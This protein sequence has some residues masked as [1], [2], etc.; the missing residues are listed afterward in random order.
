MTPET[1]PPTVESGTSVLFAQQVSTF[2]GSIQQARFVARP[3]VKR[4]AETALT[5]SGRELLRQFGS[6]RP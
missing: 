2:G 6:K 3:A 4:I 1:Q 5:D